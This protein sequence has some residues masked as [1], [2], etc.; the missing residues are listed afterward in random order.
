MKKV[1]TF[2][3][4]LLLVLSI[5]LCSAYADTFSESKWR[6]KLINYSQ[7]DLLEIIAAAQ[8]ILQAETDAEFDSLVAIRD[9]INLAIWNSQQWQ[10]VS[11]PPGVWEIG[12]DIPAGHWSVRPASG[13]GPAYIIYAS[14]TKDQGHDVD[15]FAGEYIMECICDPSASFYSA[16]YKTTTDFVLESGRFVRLD[17]TMVFS[18]YSGKPDFG[19]R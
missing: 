10:E 14:A 1:I 12:V 3:I 18:P 16:D 9:Q 19:F 5:L 7:Q 15:L 2:V 4:T 11:V 13:C 8:H 6:W 17:C